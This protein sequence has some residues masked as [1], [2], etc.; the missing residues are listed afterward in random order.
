VSDRG[1]VSEISVCGSEEPGFDHYL[2]PTQI[3]NPDLNL[4]LMGGKRFSGERMFLRLFRWFWVVREREREPFESPIPAIVAK[5]VM[6][7]ADV[8]NF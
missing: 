8:L 5:S 7:G 6:L 3:K 4:H 1:A 2:R